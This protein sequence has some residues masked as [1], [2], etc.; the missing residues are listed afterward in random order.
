MIDSSAAL[1]AHLEPL[2][3]RCQEGHS[4]AFRELYQ[5]Y[6]KAMY[7][8]CYRIVN[9]HADAEDLLQEGFTQAFRRINSFDGRST[10]GYWL[11]RIMINTSISYLRKKRLDIQPLDLIH[12]KQLPAEKVT[13]EEVDYNIHQIHH[14]I[15]ELPTGYRTVLS[16]YLLEGYDHKEI[17]QILNV[18]ESTTRTQYLRARKKLQENL[19]AL[20]K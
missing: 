16:L 17:A 1:E 20:S 4:D 12:E 2:V 19:K 9:S 7:N 11:K 15:Q 5:R 6:S 8:T 10:I 14:C 18:A 3:V 13:P